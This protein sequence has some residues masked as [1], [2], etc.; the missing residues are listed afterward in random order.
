V[1]SELYYPEETSTGAFLT[2]TAEGLACHFPVEV[3]CSQ[4]TYG[5][6]GLRAPVNEVRNS[7]N[8]HRCWG[9][10]F[11][12]DVL[13]LR[14]LNMFTI[15]LSIMFNA[16]GRIRAGDCVLVVTNPP[17]LPL[18]VALAC[19]IRRAKCILI[20]HDVYPDVLIAAGVLNN[21]SPLA[22]MVAHVMRALYRRM[23]RIVVLGRDM[24]M[25]IH[26][27]VPDHGRI[28]HI[29]NWADLGLVKPLPR[30][31]NNLLNELG[32][33]GKFVVQYSGNIGRTH[34]IEYLVQCA[35]Q[36]SDETQLHFLFI[37]FGGGKAWLK[38][39]VEDRGLKNVS[40]LDYRTR[41]ELS[42]SLNACD[43]A[44][45]SLA[46]GMAGVSVPSRM[47][48]VMAAGKPIIAVTDTSSELALAIRDEDVGWVVEPGNMAALK[49]AIFDAQGDLDRLN[50]MGLRAR[51]AA[52]T[53]YT[54]EQ[55]N[56]SYISLVSSLYSPAKG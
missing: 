30:S 47:Y 49:A 22:E 50:Q 39:A 56:A 18:V 33:A 12:K 31:E 10:T 55:A 3:L 51:R 29:P 4:P 7:V 9:T 21:G 46:K 43:I 16:I 32:L 25:L 8:I 1:I 2:Q 5:A 37:G 52:E 13:P 35:E 42:F 17:L 27:K 15:A 19:F 28:I 53:K 20:I 26:S 34:G 36:M 54:F 23:D 38:R 6:R 14:M 44:I 45:I 48:N 41:S 11:N 24:E 40:V